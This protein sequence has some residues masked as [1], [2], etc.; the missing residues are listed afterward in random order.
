QSTVST[1]VERKRGEN[2]VIT[3]EGA[4]HLRPGRGIDRRG[5]RVGGTWGGRQYRDPLP[6]PHGERQVAEETTK[7]VF[8]TGGRRCAE[9]LIGLDVVTLG[10]A[11]PYQSEL[12]D[13][14]RHR[15]LGGV[16]PHPVKPL[17]ELL[18]GGDL[19]L[20]DQGEDRLLSLTF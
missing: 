7:P 14:A 11:D 17:D 4:D 10:S 2:R 20:G 12:G 1:R 6:A 19:M 3:G 9:P 16:D 8:A 15:R 18:L 5:Q 13:I